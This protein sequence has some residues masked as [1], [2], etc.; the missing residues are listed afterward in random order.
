VHPQEFQN[1][2]NCHSAILSRINPQNWM[3]MHNQFVENHLKT[4]PVHGWM[5]NETC[6]TQSWNWNVKPPQYFLTGQ[7]NCSDSVS[8]C[9]LKHMYRVRRKKT[10]KCFRLVLLTECSHEDLGSSTNLSRRYLLAS[11]Q[12]QYQRLCQCLVFSHINW[13]QTACPTY[14]HAHAVIVGNQT[15]ETQ[16]MTEDYRSAEVW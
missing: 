14:K 5:D 3:A 11:Q 10:E 1:T 7:A 6:Q 13:H 16:F 15:H 4:S 12:V 8:Q 2:C 9:T